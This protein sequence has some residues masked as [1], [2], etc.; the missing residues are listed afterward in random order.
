MVVMVIPMARP[1]LPKQ[2]SLLLQRPIHPPN[3]TDL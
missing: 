2:P 1:L 3:K